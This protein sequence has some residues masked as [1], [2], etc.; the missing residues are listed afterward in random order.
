VTAPNLLEPIAGT[1]AVNE[2]ITLRWSS[3][4][5]QSAY[6]VRMRD[7]AAVTWNVLDTALAFDQAD[8]YLIAASTLASDDFEW[9]V[10]VVNPTVYPSATTYPDATLYP[11]YAALPPVAWSASA[12]FAGRL[13]PA[14]PTIDAPLAGE[15]IDKSKYTVLWT[16][17]DLPGVL[18]A[19]QR[20]RVRRTTLDD[21]VREDSGEVVST[22]REYLMSIDSTDVHRRVEV[23]VFYDGLWS[24]WKSHQV[25]V[26]FV[27]PPIPVISVLAVKTVAGAGEFTDALSV[28]ITN[29]PPGAEQPA[30]ARNEVHRRLAAALDEGIRLAADV[31]QGATFVDHTPASGQPYAYRVVAVGTDGNPTATDWQE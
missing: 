22:A 4:K 24:P 23:Q 3:P 17:A 30:V 21:V 10:G 9:Q 27:G 31:A 13:R 28:A 29:P 20:Y 19:Q 6:Q 8:T 18:Q 1:V 26:F 15:T 2:P 11:S 14:A 16:P 12:F 5:F 7:D 25:Y